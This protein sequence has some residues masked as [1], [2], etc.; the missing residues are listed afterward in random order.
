MNV[1]MFWK[2]FLTC[3][4]WLLINTVKP[5]QTTLCA[6]KNLGGDSIVCVCNSDYCDTV[7][8]NGNP[9]KN[10]YNLYQSSKLGHRLN[11][12]A[13]PFEKNAT[14]ENIF[15]INI[16]VTYQSILGF[17]GAFT[18]A[19][20]INILSLPED[21]Q[22]KLIQSYYSPD[23]IEYTIGRIPMA[24]CDFST[25]PYSYDDSPMDFSLSNFSLAMED[26]KYKIPI[27]QKALSIS[28]REISIFGSPWSAPAWMKTNNNMTGRGSLIGQ[29]GGKY[30]KTWANYFIKFLDAYKSHNI[31]LWGL[32]A[33]NEPTDGEIYKF[34][35]QA[36]GWTAEMQRDFIIQ[37]LGPALH[38]NGYQDIQLMIMD[39]QRLVLPEWTS[40][41][42]SDKTA[43]QYI[44]GTA[45]HWYTDKII[46][47]GLLTYAHDK[48]PDK[49]IF[50]TEA[51]N[52]DL[53]WEK[54]VDLGSWERAESYSHYIL[55][56]LNHWVTGWTDWNIAL[57][58][59]GGP[60]WVSNFV[61]SPIIVNAD[62]REFYKQ[63]MFY[64]LGHFSKFVLP[65]SKR[66][67]IKQNG[68]SSLELAAFILPD[69]SKVVVVLNRSDKEETFSI[70]D[71]AVGFINAQ[72][73]A[74]AIQTYIW[75]NNQS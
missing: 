73:P 34:P 5:V 18:D 26:L 43:S 45:I 27:I 36:M 59:Q 2:V 3:F 17:G 41:I 67:D 61:D 72:I 10:F 30:F 56:D 75:W 46:P 32:T 29:P 40:V 9:G 13:I 4:C 37:D 63:P 74:H 14:T 48:Y 35:F 60:N 16:N 65:G 68:I 7:E 21:V 70:N 8:P 53:P 6:Q 25:H 51:C 62:K 42:L 57:D 38:N 1:I 24:S 52:G 47:S 50:A 20:G 54:H 15:Y 12:T 39:D 22:E 19:A 49:F 31:S 71:P 23:G 11:Y 33:Q 64:A 58:M 55:Q 44:A 28:S 69:S 66:V